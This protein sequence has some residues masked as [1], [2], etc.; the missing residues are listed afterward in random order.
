MKKPLLTILLFILLLQIKA[1]IIDDEAL[2]DEQHSYQNIL[3]DK[4]NALKDQKYFEY[5]RKNKIKSITKLKYDE[6]NILSS[7]DIRSFS[8]YG[9]LTSIKEYYDD[10]LNSEIKMIYDERNNLTLRVFSGFVDGC[11][12][13]EYIIDS[14]IMKYNSNNQLTFSVINTDTVEYEYNSIG[15]RVSESYIYNDNINVIKSFIYQDSNLI[16]V[17][18][19]IPKD[20][21]ETIQSIFKYDKKSNCIINILYS[22]GSIECCRV[23]MYDSLDHL[24]KI[25]HINKEMEASFIE[26]YYYLNNNLVKK[27]ESLDEGSVNCL[28]T[29]L[30]DSN[31]LLI[32]KTRKRYDNGYLGSD[33]YTYDAVG[34]LIDFRTYYEGKLFEE[35]KSTYLNGVLDLEEN[36]FEGAFESKSKYIYEFYEL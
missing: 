4:E 21:S 36:Y 29:L 31:N 32:V 34:N 18:Y 28:D 10:K 3:I 9:Y 23:Y 11:D 17:T 19:K 2:R 6:K 12:G 20:T 22:L 7:K 35:T 5:I 14:S 33:K 8:K 27:T 1:Q 15:K 24:I 25:K 26:D 30:Y 13:P 16:K